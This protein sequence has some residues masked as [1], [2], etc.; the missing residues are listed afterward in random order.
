MPKFE[1]MFFQ[2][3]YFFNILYNGYNS[4]SNAYPQSQTKI[5]NPN[6]N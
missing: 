1:Y 4:V 6:L 3:K 5:P 2:K